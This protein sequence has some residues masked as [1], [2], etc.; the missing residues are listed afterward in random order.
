[1]SYFLKTYD[2]TDISNK[3][4]PETDLS[5]SVWNKIYFGKYKGKPIP[6]RIISK[7][8]REFGLA[9]DYDAFFLDCDT[10][11]EQR[12]FAA[13]GKNFGWPNTTLH[14][15]LN[16]S[17]TK[18]F[19]ESEL[20]AV[21]NC[22][23]PIDKLSRPK[24]GPQFDQ[25]YSDKFFVPDVS[26]LPGIMTDTKYLKYVDQYNVPFFYWLRSYCP[27]GKKEK[28]GAALFPVES[29]G[30]TTQ[31]L[32]Y[33]D[34]TQACG[35]SPSC[36]L[37]QEKII[38]STKVS[39]NTYKLTV[40]DKD[41]GWIYVDLQKQ[42]KYDKGKVTIPYF[43]NHAR[44][45]FNAVSVLILDKKYEE[46]KYKV[47]VKLL[48]YEL[49][50]TPDNFSRE[51]SGSF[52]LPRRL[53]IED[54]GVKYH[55]YLMLEEI[56]GEN[57]TDYG[58][59]SREISPYD[60]EGTTWTR[61][62]YLD[63][64]DKKPYFTEYVLKT[65]NESQCKP[66]TPS[67]AGYEFLG[68]YKK[69]GTKYDFS[70]RL[71]GDISLYADW[72]LIP[73]VELP[74]VTVTEYKIWVGSRLVTSDNAG[75]IFGDGSVSYDSD[76]KTLN[77][78]YATL[79]PK[80]SSRYESDC[81]IRV[82]EDLT[83]TG[84]AD[85]PSTYAKHGI[86]V[87]KGVT[88][89]INATLSLGA[90]EYGIYGFDAKEINV[91]GSK[92]TIK[93]T[94]YGIFLG[95][96][97]PIGTGLNISDS[98][99]EIESET[100]GIIV[101]KNGKIDIDDNIVV[102]EPR[103]FDIVSQ[104][105]NG[106]NISVLVDEYGEW[107]KRVFMAPGSVYAD[108]ELEDGLE[109]NTEWRRYEHVFTTE[110]IEP[111]VYVR[112]GHKNPYALK[113]GVDYTLSY[114]NN[115]RAGDI[116]HPAVCTINYKGNFKGTDK[117]HFYILPKPIGNYKDSTPAEGIV[118]TDV[119]TIEGS[120]EFNV[121]MFY[122]GHRI[123]KEYYKVYTN[124]ASQTID[125]HGKYDYSEAIKGVK[126]TVISRTD[127]DKNKIK[128]HLCFTYDG[129][130]KVFGSDELSAVDGYDKPIDAQNYF[131]QY[132]DNLNVGLAKAH[133][134]AKSGSGYYG[135][136]VIYYD[137]LPDINKSKVTTEIA[138][139][140]YYDKNG[141][142]PP[143]KVTATRDKKTRTLEEGKDY[144][145]DYSYNS[146]NPLKGKYRVKFIGN[147]KGRAPIVCAMVLQPAP[148]TAAKVSA[149]ASDLIY[150]EPGDY[151]AVVYASYNGALLDP[152]DYTVRYLVGD[153]DI[154]DNKKF[155]LEGDKAAV[156]VILK[157]KGCYEE[158]EVRIDN[159]YYIVKADSAS[160]SIDLS[161]ASLVQPG[162][163]KA[164][165]NQQCTG[166][167]IEPPIDFKFNNTGLTLNGANERLKEGRDYKVYYFDNINA[168]TAFVF[169]KAIIT[170]GQAIN[171][172]TGT[173]KI[174]RRET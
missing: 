25:L 115:K 119:T 6:W 79:G 164:L 98:T 105:Q 46:R 89:N 37:L 16:G 19:S 83:I 81:L 133:V 78:N 67:K 145:V 12:P 36:V 73:L 34:K 76:T 127:A 144:T 136:S 2:N 107:A 118:L 157:G 48:H 129:E 112:V 123:E 18:N 121:T 174:V 14:N 74:V 166:R 108:F 156:S 58:C 117:L 13:D 111:K 125:I 113:E 26:E 53:K 162:T 80:N 63:E 85:L 44:Q 56:H 70:K 71:T 131:V 38:L 75:D 17:F 1:M 104:K 148:F 31:E 88:L 62:Y 66:N 114:S 99:L 4:I 100:C 72:K 116:T 150:T 159:C 40:D 8:S 60:I 45:A 7:K 59:L 5:R 137:I 168:G 103:R 126:Y 140:A 93:N 21:N 135:E 11:L 47:D 142:K 122:N 146:T 128:G 90:K 20:D 3:M 54:W 61:T 139:K 161:K 51:E 87:D 97:E 102:S 23:T 57:E 29:R 68:W 65:T 28:L 151:N 50:K 106:H 147:Y 10:V 15:Y 163:T 171:S 39:R 95:G 86:Y 167:P 92:L 153:V 109:Y 55:V 143:V 9:A 27:D 52:D 101:F 149:V 22:M 69:D 30:K 49:L 170:G 160:G 172:T 77:F 24:T 82:G 42:A 41:G 110:N 165:P 84:K 154:T 132:E 152:K 141:A 158:K 64:N 155:T 124:G 96:F 91:N 130:P 35:V 94:S 120:N 32:Q 173:F 33:L 43:V 169:V 134:T 138:G